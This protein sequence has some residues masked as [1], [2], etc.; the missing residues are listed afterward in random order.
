MGAPGLQVG[1]LQEIDYPSHTLAGLGQAR[2]RA[3]VVSGVAQH[4]TDLM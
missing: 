1:F 3:G 4:G 2:L